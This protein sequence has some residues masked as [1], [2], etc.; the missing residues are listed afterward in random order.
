M[1]KKILLPLCFILLV[2]SCKNENNNNS[3]ADERFSSSERF[4]SLLENYYEDGLRLDPISATTSGDMRYN[5]QFPDF[6]SQDYEDSLRNYYTT[7]K[8]KASRIDDEALSESEK[9]SKKILL[10]ECNIN[11]ESMNFENARYMPID[12]MWS[13]NLFMGQLA[14]GVSSQPFKTVEDYE[15]WL[16]RVDGFLTWLNSAEERMREGMELG[17]VLPASL[18]VKVIP[19][20]EAMANEDQNHLFYGPVKNSPESFTAEEK[21]DLTA[22]YDEMVRNKVI[23]AYRKMQNFMEEEYKQAGRES[24]GITDIPNGEAFYMHQIKKYTTTDMTAEEIHQLGL[25]E[26]ERISAEMEKIKDEVGYEGDLKSF[27]TYVRDSKKLM[28]FSTS[29]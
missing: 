28:P 19:Q 3:E 29:G 23:P 26:V 12:Q 9:M 5:D 2:S 6:L 21:E 24:S 4:D 16:K 8:Q 22:K 7:Y 1:L 27:F 11:L 17:Y 15:N 14:S 20:M 10:W 13:V 25:D 18:I